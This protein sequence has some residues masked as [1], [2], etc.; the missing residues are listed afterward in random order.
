MQIL[1]CKVI[2]N[3]KC[4]DG[5]FSTPC[6]LLE[7]VASRFSCKVTFLGFLVPTFQLKSGGHA[8]CNCLMYEYVCL[9]CIVLMPARLC[10]ACALADTY[11]W[12]LCETRRRGRPPVSSNSEWCYLPAFILSIFFSFFVVPLLVP[13]P[14]NVLVNVVVCDGAM[15][16]M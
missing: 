2:Q 10:V 4:K 8:R 14:V 12:F 3:H 13:L 7:V 16:W 1:V 9:R 5:Q 11:I 6:C 15:R